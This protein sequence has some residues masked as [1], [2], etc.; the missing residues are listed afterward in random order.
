MQRRRRARAPAYADWCRRFDNLGPA[1]RESL[2]QRQAALPG[3]PQ[4]ALLLLVP[5]AVDAEPASAR[6]ALWASLRAQ[7]FPVW[8]LLIGSAPDSDSAALAW[9]Q[10]RLVEDPRA[11]LVPLQERGAA[12][13]RA[14]VAAANAPWVAFT[15]AS[16]QWREHA[17]LLLAEATLRERDAVLVYADEDRLN[18]AG[19]RV[20]PRFKCDWNPELLLGEECIGAPALWRADALQACDALQ[21]AAD[22][23]WQHDLA[24]RAT[25]GRP[26][27]CIV[28][29]P[30]VLLHRRSSPPADA[31]ASAQVVQAHL[32]RRGVAAHAEALPAGV[33]VRFALPTPPPAVTI[34]I[35][36]R[37]GLD[38]LRP[39]VD[40]LLKLTTYPRFD[41]LIVDNASDDPA[42]VEYLRQLAGRPG[43]GVLRDERPFNYSAL[44]NA[45]VARA[46]GEFVALLNNDIEVISP[47]WL[48]EM[49][50]LAAQPGVGAVG[51][52]LWYS[53]DTLQHGGIILGLNGFAGHA[54]RGARADE[55]GSH[56]R[57]HRLQRLCAVTAACLVV[58]RS[59]YLQAGGLDEQTF[60]VALND[61]DFCLRLR[62]AGLRILW[63]PFADLYHHESRTRGS[64]FQDPARRQRFERERDAFLQRW[65]ALV[66]H[67]PAYNPNLTLEREDFSLADPPRVGLL[68][69]WFEDRGA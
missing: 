49:V 14:L 1:E 57:L 4:I 36:T 60:G 20:A 12:G 58:R 67:D 17:L 6:A 53:D 28:H 22:A 26:D 32:D 7:M 27:H 19:R 33:R 39:C 61:V 41:L 16:E 69:P 37:N 54:H 45:A 64:D 25:E 24:L 21:T 8:S 13:R 31:A 2:Q 46:G 30:H 62:A 18:A 63:T 51:A 5:A 29:V 68:R 35:P 38:L 50:A 11:R 42:C 9:W 34:V 66:Q 47:G 44:N 52:R 65:A 43:V 40:S 23:A 48:D 10:A 59:T 55:P 15:D 3:L 56:L